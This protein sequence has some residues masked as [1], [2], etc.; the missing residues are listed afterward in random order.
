MLPNITERLSA[1]STS[2]LF[3]PLTFSKVT[4][5]FSVVVPDLLTKCS[6]SPD[7]A[8]ALAVR[9]ERSPAPE[10]ERRLKTVMFAERI[11][12]SVYTA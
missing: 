8:G 1:C 4:H 6:V 12:A 11:P 10:Q 2:P 3:I 5:Y 9:R 7:P